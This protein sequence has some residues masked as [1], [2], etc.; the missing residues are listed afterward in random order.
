MEP[1]N[2]QAEVAA[3]C[4]FHNFASVKNDKEYIPPG[5]VY[6]INRR[7]ERLLGGGE[8]TLSYYEKRY[9]GNCLPSSSFIT[10]HQL[11]DL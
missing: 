5:S 3:T 9:S 1:K 7:P 4:V 8:S 2:A 11:P 10:N 6:Q